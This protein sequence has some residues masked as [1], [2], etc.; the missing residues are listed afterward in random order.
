MDT[1]S[2]TTEAHAL[3]ALFNQAQTFA[4]VKSTTAGFSLLTPTGFRGSVVDKLSDYLES[5]PEANDYNSEQMWV[6][7]QALRLEVTI[8]ARQEM[9]ELGRLASGNS[10]AAPAAREY[11]IDIL[12]SG[13]A[14]QPDELK[15][16]CQERASEM[17]RNIACQTLS[18]DVIN[19]I[20]VC[21]TTRMDLP[22]TSRLQ[23]LEAIRTAA[24]A[25]D[26]KRAWV[27]TNEQA[28]HLLL[29]ALELELKRPTDMQCDTYIRHLFGM[30]REYR[31]GATIQVLEVVAA[32]TEQQH[33]RALA[34]ETLT[35]IRQSLQERWQ[36][37][38]ANLSA[39][40]QSQSHRL[41]ETA[42]YNRDSDELIDAIFTTT[43]GRPVESLTDPRL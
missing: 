37:T 16:Y 12:I 15:E 18:A 41:V 13:A 39:P 4:E 25:C 35:A 26:E 11:L 20:K 19:G 32:S 24:T 9:D 14:E 3:S 30:M 28:A 27:L 8:A 31:T 7:Y 33:I 5:N 29:G 22:Q 40:L 42:S 23:L 38:R 17:V 6:L 34:A 2:S 36:N 21:L 43:K 10:L 1:F